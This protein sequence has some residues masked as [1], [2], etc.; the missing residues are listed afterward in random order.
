MMKSKIALAVLLTTFALAPASAA[1]SKKAAKAS[2]SK[3]VKATK[4]KAAKGPTAKPAEPEN[5]AVSSAPAER[6]S[7]RWMDTTTQHFLNALWKLDPESAIAS[8]KFE[9][10]ATLT[11]PSA[12]TRA[13]ELAFADEWLQRLAKMEARKLSNKQRTDLALL[14]NKLKA[15]RWYLTTFKEHEWNPALYNIAK[16]IDIVLTTEYAA[17]PQRLRTLLRR[18]ATVPAYYQ[19]AQASIVN[20]TREHLQLAIAQAPGT[21]TVL[22]DL[23][24][25]AQESILTPQEKTIFAQRVANAGTALIGYIDFLYAL[26]RSKQANRS[27]RIGQDLYE[28]KFAH[29]IQA[30]GSAGQTY[31]KALA[32]R[33]ELLVR[34]NGLADELWPKVMG[35]VAKP[36]DRQQKIGLVIG[37]LSANHV[38]RENFFPEIR[39]QIPVLQDWV[40]KNNLLTLDPRRPLEVRETPLYQRGVAGASIV[41]PGPYRPQVKTYYNVTPMDGLS[42]QEAESSLREYN[43]WILQILNIHEAVPGHYAQLVYANKSPSL[44]KSL[45]GNGAMVEGWAVYAERMMLESG[46]ENSP[47]MWLMYSKWNLRSVTNTI[48]DYSV[49]VLGM[50]QPQ[51]MD[52]LVRQAFQTPA[53]AAEK[54]RRVQLSSVQLTSYFSGYSEIMELREQRKQALGQG[55]VLK[56]FH[57]QF[58][59][60]GNAPVKVIRELMQ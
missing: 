18:I 51:A 2:T 14:I 59:S 22:A 37:R 30:A 23:G 43:H 12:A 33:E 40:V 3:T 17:K 1:K 44:V 56:D 42:A 55:F 25:A 45:F 20:P 13:R 38:A 47:E 35:N 57:D 4:A 36:V 6:K 28:A 10:A 21:M 46:Y 7:D 39:R 5:A 24:K 48:L 49:H 53:E 27:F 29:D 16:P 34:M 31:Q 19:A 32:A 15:D 60:Y 52:L 50:T 8:G 11:I 54:W 26:D 41:A 9:G 58:L